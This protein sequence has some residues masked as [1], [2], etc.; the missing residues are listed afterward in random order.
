MIKN[1]KYF[2]K[3]TGTDTF[4]LREVKATAGLFPRVGPWKEED[5]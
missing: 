1:Y 3:L 5:G 2:S 4:N